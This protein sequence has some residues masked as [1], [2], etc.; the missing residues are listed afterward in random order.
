MS[1]IKIHSSNKRI[2]GAIISCLVFILICIWFIIDPH[3]FINFKRQN[4][5]TIQIIGVIGL[6]FF[7]V[8]LLSILYKLFD[9]KKGLTFSEGG[10]FDNSG[11]ASAGFV[12]WEDVLEIEKIIVYNQTLVLVLVKNPE[13]YINNQKSMIKRK[14]MSSN[15]SYYRT[16]IQI[17]A[18]FLKIN[19]EDL[20]ELF[21]SQFELYKSKM[22]K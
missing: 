9:R 12:K 8:L 18:N 6:I 14:L 17:S 10:F 3:Q 13:D 1:E 16:P 20:L 15:N 22:K 2:K 4:E 11:G 21:E 7:L 5:F 19:F